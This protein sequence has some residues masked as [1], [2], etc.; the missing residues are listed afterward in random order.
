MTQGERI[1]EVRKS[2]GLTLEKFGEKIGVTKVA[3]SNL[4]NGHR[5]L[6]EQMT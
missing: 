6:T 5:N 2:L 4:E 1:K 3:I